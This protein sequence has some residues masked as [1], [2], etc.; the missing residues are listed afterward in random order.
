MY[1]PHAEL[2]LFG[3]L[4]ILSSAQTVEPNLAP[5]PHWASPL[6]SIPG[7]C[8]AAPLPG[9]SLGTL[10]APYPLEHILAGNLQA[11][12]EPGQLVPGAQEL[13]AGVL[14]VPLELCPALGH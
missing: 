3:H 5:P 7:V 11:C 12:V 9:G 6:C 2:L 13:D 8:T 10:H 14:T 1:L 4:G